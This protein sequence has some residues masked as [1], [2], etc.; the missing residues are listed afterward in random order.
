MK[1]DLSQDWL[2]WIFENVQKGC[3]KNELLSTLLN[4]GFDIIQCKV[5]LDF[6]RAM[7]SF[8]NLSTV[9]EQNNVLD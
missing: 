3:D 5:A 9:T 7:H 2:D 8:V 4:E 1:K 6:R